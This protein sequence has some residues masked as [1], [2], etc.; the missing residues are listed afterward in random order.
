[1]QERTQQIL[2]EREKRLERLR[3]QLEEKKKLTFKPTISEYQFN[4]KRDSFMNTIDEQIQKR[5]EFIEQC[6]KERKE[7][8][9]AMNKSTFAPSVGLGIHVVNS[10]RYLRCQNSWVLEEEMSTKD[11][12]TK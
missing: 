12:I 10:S 9:D 11:C 2:L 4:R 7:K 3:F 5:R 8:E 1:M 6:E